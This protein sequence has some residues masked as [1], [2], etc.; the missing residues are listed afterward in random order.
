MEN[1]IEREGLMP[2]RTDVIDKIN[3]FPKIDK[4]TFRM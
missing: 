4:M 3:T 1:M 2:K